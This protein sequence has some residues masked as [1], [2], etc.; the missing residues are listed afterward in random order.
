[1]FPAVSPN[2]A[3]A[4]SGRSDKYI[5]ALIEQDVLPATA[6]PHRKIPLAAIETLIGRP[7]TDQDILDALEQVEKVRKYWRDYQRR[8]KARLG[9]EGAHP[10]A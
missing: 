7:V 1:M 5:R 10:T 2:L 4:L 8:K 3:A 9:A 6:G